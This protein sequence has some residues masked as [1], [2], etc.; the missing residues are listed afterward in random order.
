MYETYSN[1]VETLSLAKQGSS[2]V[3]VSND[4]SSKSAQY[5]QNVR[6]L[7]SSRIR[8]S[9]PVKVSFLYDEPRRYLI[10]GIYLF[11]FVTG[12]SFLVHIRIWEIVHPDIFVQ[13]C[14]IS[15]VRR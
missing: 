4:L 6:S 10:E 8:F 2:S 7:K 11:I 13:L 12:P 15:H 3:R 14:I 9:N 5:F 1:Y